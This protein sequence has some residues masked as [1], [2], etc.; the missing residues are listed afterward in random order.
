MK[1]KNSK[2]SVMTIWLILKYVQNWKDKLD[3][4]CLLKSQVQ[5][6]SFTVKITISLSGMFYL[7]PKSSSSQHI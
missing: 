1:L 7:L 3:S 6:L 5:E 2:T 4:R